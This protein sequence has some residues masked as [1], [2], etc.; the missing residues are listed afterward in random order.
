MQSTAHPRHLPQ[1]SHEFRRRAW[2][3]FQAALDR[4][5]GI[6]RKLLRRR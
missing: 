5:L 6:N 1:P 2:L 4:H 3:A